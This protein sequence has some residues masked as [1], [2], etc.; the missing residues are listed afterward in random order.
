MRLPPVMSAVA[1]HLVEPA[2]LIPRQRPAWAALALLSWIVAAAL[3]LTLPPEPDQFHHAYMGWRWVEGDIP[4]RDFID[5]NWP[6]VIG[7]NAIASW[8]FGVHIW[9]WRAADFLLF[10][11]SAVLLA[12]LVRLAEGSRAGRYCLILSPLIYAGV[13]AWISGQHDMS[14]THFLVATAWCHVRAYRRQDW[15]WQVVAG[16]LLA[17]AM[18]CKPTV[19]L[20]GVLLP[21][22]ALSQRI[23]YRTVLAHTAVLAASSLAMLAAAMAG[24]VALGTPMSDLVDAIYRYNVA[25]QFLPN[26]IG[27]AP[28]GGQ[29]HA[30]V[31]RVIARV[32]LAIGQEKAQWWVGITLLG[33][34]T[35]VR[36]LRPRHR[37]LAGSALIALWLT[38]VLSLLVQGRGFG[39]HL[40]PCVPALIGGLT[41]SIS[42]A[43]S[44]TRLGASHRSRQLWA[45]SYLVIA[46]LWIAQR[47]VV[48][49]YS[50]PLSLVAG[51]YR[52]HLSRFNAG[53]Q[54]VVSDVV[55]FAR[56]IEK[57]DKS[58]C[59]LSVGSV[60]AVNYLSRHRQ[61]TR[62][63]YFPV[64]AKAR[65][66]LPMAE[67]WLDLW[68]SDLEKAD[69]QYILIAA[70]IDRDWLAS[71]G[72]AAETLRALL[73]RYRRTG[74]LGATGGMVIYERAVP[75][76]K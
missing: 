26:D 54:L 2:P 49:F 18:L 13:D 8:A 70:D 57:S 6:G 30:G 43:A 62:F 67:R 1:P 61:P 68:E 10:M 15:R 47:I 36:W 41:A 23:S 37:T 59:L 9:S 50:L 58:G 11:A 60:S 29:V 42:R 31:R 75:I 28:D 76:E 25:T 66:P 73:Q 34:P 40:S 53:D 12:D 69:C 16:A 56:K 21:L 63:Y 17:A 24:V 44:W 74:T 39:Y 14:A 35:F 55:D 33:L 64:I 51:D 5:M 32:W 65:P 71:P 48:S 4:Y 19:G 20:L 7:L 27:I 72:R 3:Y 46:S 45:T 52:G 38:G 22:Q